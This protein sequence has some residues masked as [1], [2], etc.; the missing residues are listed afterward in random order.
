TP[1]GIAVDRRLRTTNRRAFAI[2]DAAGGPQFT[3]VALHH[4]GVV[5]KNALFHIPA[6]VDLRALPR[7]VYTDPELAQ[8]GL[9]EPAAR[10]A[11]GS[12]RVLR[13]PFADNDRAHAERDTAGLVKVFATRGGRILG[14]AILGAGAGDLILAW[15]L[16]IARRLPLRAMTDLVVPYPTRGEASKRAAASLYTPALFSAR[17]RRLVRLLARLG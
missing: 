1:E 12:V 13:W 15:A 6:R 17:T 4:A 16:A 11:G 10:A 9:D 7:V 8:V 14:A 3:H 2:G 5:I